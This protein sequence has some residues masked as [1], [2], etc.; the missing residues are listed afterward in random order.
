[1][2]GAAGMCENNYAD[3]MKGGAN[4]TPAPRGR[5]PFGYRYVFG[6]WRHMET[7]DP[8]DPQLHVSGVRARKQACMHRKYWA[9]GGRERR[10]ARYTKK[11]KPKPQQLT[12]CDAVPSEAD[13]MY[14]EMYSG[15]TDLCE[16]LPSSQSSPPAATCSLYLAT[17]PSTFGASV[18]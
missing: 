12:L 1:M 13:K 5:P 3:A 15:K 7:G 2:L 6:E 8:F 14:S 18:A 9:N 4:H 16:R 10:L 11:R 17:R